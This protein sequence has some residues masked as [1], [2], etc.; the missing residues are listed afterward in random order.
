[1]T[2]EITQRFYTLQAAP[3]LDN[4]GF[5]KG[6]L[7]DRQPL[8]FI[9]PANT[10]LRLR[11][12]DVAKGKATFR[13]LCDDSQVEKKIT[14]N[15]NWQ[16]ISAT[17]DTVPFVDTLY[18][19]ENEEITVI[20]ELPPTTKPLP[21]WST[22]QSESDFFSYW[23][24]NTS[25][26]A[27]VDTN[28]ICFLLPL[29]DRDNL[30]KT[31]LSTLEMYYHDIFNAYNDWAGLSDT[32]DS[33]LDKNVP[34][35]YFIKADK[36]G[37][38][39]AYYLPWWCAETSSTI[40]EGWIDNITT[41][42]TILHEIGHGY[43]GKFM[44]DTEIP[45]GEVWN[46]IYAA[47]FQQKI[48][49]SHDRLYT[50]GWLYNYGQQPDE[51]LKFINNVKN[52]HPVAQWGVRTRLLF[53]MMMLFKAK[54]AAFRAFNQQYR[55]LANS[56]GFLPG[57]HRLCDLLAN[58]IASASGYDMTPFMTFCGLK[59][60]TLTCE[61]ASAYAAK[62]VWPLFD[63]LA[64]KEWESARQSLNLDSFVW[65]VDNQQLSALNK[66]GSVSFTL[67]IDCPEQ[68]YGK[69]LTLRDNDGHAFSIKI[70]DNP[71]TLSDIPIGVYQL[72]LPLG[73]SQ[74][75]RVD[76]T[77]VTVREGINAVTVNYTL[78]SDTA[79]R[80]TTLHFL[81]YDNTPFATLSVDYQHQ[82]LILD[83]FSATPHLYFSSQRYASVTVYSA[84]GKQLLKRDMSGT[85]CTTGKF[86][87]PLT[88]NDH[89]VIYHAEPGRLKCSPGYLTLI[90][91]QPNQLLRIDRQGLYN[92][93]LNNKP[94][95]D[96][97]TIFIHEAG[98]FRQLPA[99]EN[100]PHSAQK[101]EFWLMLPHFSDTLRASLVND[102]RDVLPADNS[103]PGA[104]TGKQLTVTLRGLNDNEFCQ[105][106]IDNVK[107]N[108]VV[109]TRQGQPHAYYTAS[110]ASIMVKNKAGEEVYYRSYQG[111]ESYRAETENIALEEGFSIEVFH[112]EPF[113]LSAIN[114]TQNAPVNVKK[115]NCWYVVADGLQEPLSPQPSQD[116]PRDDARLYG[117]HFVWD[118]LGD[119]DHCFASMNFDIGNKQFTFSAHAGVPHKA[120]S[121]IYATVNLYNTRGSVIARQ[122]I[123]GTAGLGDYVDVATLEEG[124]IIEVT[125][126]E[127]GRRSVIA[128]PLNGESFP[129]AHNARWRVTPLG[130]ERL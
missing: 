50:D 2:Q 73:R 5:E 78:L 26:F 90:A 24:K 63:L 57:D 56:E 92:F 17:V 120:F 129:Q 71:L 104:L 84:S 15:N 11:Q 29:A 117:A 114:L 116:V 130:I 103:T 122:A 97:Y 41:Q 20:Y 83:I 105:I 49:S 44:K 119:N 12:P 75:Y 48:L 109:Y 13:L 126:A 88:E 118:L 28:V 79:L 82:R 74:K 1:M 98:A 62:P 108:M 115:M 55:A 66:K 93:A 30:L 64:E 31:G 34:N 113:R 95:D 67:N 9:L 124:Y 42:W 32:A 111:A 121:T 46:N 69:V 80:N 68:I 14:L 23:Q 7:H 39:A 91:P 96:L 35:R 106:T 87:L 52:H 51:E 70:V 54:T 94:E 18:T 19:K 58:A 10:P 53:L 36:H 81:G 61:K 8:G 107:K 45:V 27:L 77:F 72:E 112:D 110:Y 40:S 3:W 65:L 102:Y 6:R 37:V 16:T 127:A 101:N 4:E 33:L 25:P 125:H 123:K 47:Y 59:P 85:N 86:E 43:Q 22:G 89:L 21:Y 99:R 76:A 100:R 60:D 38:G 128:N